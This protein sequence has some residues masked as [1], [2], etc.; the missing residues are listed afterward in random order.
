MQ[1]QFHLNIY[2]VNYKNNIVVH[3]LITYD[4]TNQY[5]KD[6]AAFKQFAFQYEQGKK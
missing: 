3:Y 4:E 6:L 2:R 1:L 5:T